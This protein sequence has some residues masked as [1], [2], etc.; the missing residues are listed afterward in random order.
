[1]PLLLFR[2]LPPFTSPIANGTYT[3]SIKNALNK[4]KLSESRHKLIILNKSF[5]LPQKSFCQAA[6]N[7]LCTIWHLA[8][9]ICYIIQGVANGYETQRRWDISGS[10][11]GQT[12]KSKLQ[13]KST[14]FSVLTLSPARQDLFREINR[15]PSQTNSIFSNEG[16]AICRRCLATL[17]MRA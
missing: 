7:V 5:S 2:L 16:A 14:H 12:S 11:G 6:P 17:C 9:C 1:M 15:F 8:Y 3:N 13:F 10:Q 4:V